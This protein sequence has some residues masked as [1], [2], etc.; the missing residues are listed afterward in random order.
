VV[1]VVFYSHTGVTRGIANLMAQHLSADIC[2]LVPDPPYADDYKEQAKRVKQGGYGPKL[3]ELGVDLSVY[4]TIFV[5]SPNW[6]STFAPP[7]TTLLQSADL[8]GKVIAP[9]CTHG[10]GG[11]GRINETAASLCP[12]STILPAIGF[13]ADVTGDDVS[14]A[15]TQRGF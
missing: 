7:V 10:S 15:L 9:F 8:T 3:Q 14:A 5:G 6:F 12:G 1:L 4:D 11:V 2:E 13:Y